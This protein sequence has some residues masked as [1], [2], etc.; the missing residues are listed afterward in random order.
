MENKI[1]DTEKKLEYYGS[2]RL[3]DVVKALL[4]AKKRGKKC[5]FNFNGVVLHSDTVTMNDAFLKLTCST[6]AQYDQIL[7]EHVEESRRRQEAD[8]IREEAIQK[9][10][11]QARQK[12][13]TPITQ[14]TV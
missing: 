13:V 4:E 2:G 7:K 6:K 14:E 10:V 8:R 1:K 5:Y 11:L 3:E 12:G 9:K